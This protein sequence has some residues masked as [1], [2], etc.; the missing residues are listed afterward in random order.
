MVNQWKSYLENELEA[1]GLKWLGVTGLDVKDTY[2]FYEEWLN[3]GFGAGMEYLKKHMAVR[4]EP[5]RLLEGAQ[6]ALVFGLPYYQGDKLPIGHPTVA[7]YARFRD[8]HRLFKERLDLVARKL[9]LQAH[10]YRVLVD[11]APLFERALAT[12]T[13]RGF[14]GKNTCYI[15]PEWGS[16]L[17]LGEILI[18]RDLP[19]EVRLPV[20]PNQHLAEGG[21]GICDRCQVNCPTG[22][23]D[24]D[25]QIDARKCLSYWTIENRGPIP[26]E[27]WK[28]MSLYWFGCDICQLS[29]PYNRKQPLPRL[30]ENIRVNTI[31]KLHDIVS[32]DQKQ[33]E[34]WFG[35]TPMTRPGRQGLR[36]NAFIAMVVTKDPLLP[37][38]IEAL[39]RDGGAP[40]DETLRQWESEWKGFSSSPLEFMLH[41]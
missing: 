4:R 30:S 14:L 33:Y 21:C 25:Y 27:Y 12:K 11:S 1:Q 28:W 41:L 5:A 8:Y 34:A 18:T 16:F 3:A 2:V 40:L 19:I 15:H 7:Q 36:R 38:A 20:D 24:E 23:L 17:L 29:C 32:M 9:G 31:P 22:A 37:S 6:R 13:A 26:V 39:H 10:E 35:G